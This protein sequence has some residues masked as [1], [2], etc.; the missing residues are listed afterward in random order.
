MKRKQSLTLFLKGICM[1]VADVIPGVSGGTLAL[2]LGIYAQ[3]I[4]AIKSINPAPLLAGLRWI[5]SGFKVDKKEAL[6]KSLE[7]VHLSFLIPLGAGIVLALGAGSVVVPKLMELFPEIMRGLFFGLILASVAIPWKLMNKS[8]RGRLVGALV[9]AALMA[10]GGYLSTDPNRVLDS[11]TSWS[12]VTA[13]D[14]AD[15]NSLEKLLRR[16]PSAQ[17]AEQAYWAPQNEPLRQAVAQADPKKAKELDE[18]HHA[19][20]NTVATDKRALKARALPYNDLV[21]PAGTVVQVPRPSYLF[22][23]AAGAIAI[24]AMVLPGVSGS[25]LLLV[26]GVYYFVLN[27]LKGIPLQLLD[28]QVPTDSLLYIGLFLTGIAVG[29][30]SFARVLSWLLTHY[31]TLTMGALLGLM[32]GCLRALWPFQ[33]TAQGHIS[34]VLPTAWGGLELAAVA[35]VLAGAGLVFLLSWLGDRKQEAAA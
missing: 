10:T 18:L 7:T 12:T 15:K 21:V 3:F 19:E 31:P 25:F 22:V 2:I 8:D 6:L 35:A 11:T 17:T 14:D 28:G 1:G 24:C 9:L 5:A 20:N 33:S 27:T 23:L 4:A 29:I 26:L 34:N 13:G 32:V 16:G 30:T